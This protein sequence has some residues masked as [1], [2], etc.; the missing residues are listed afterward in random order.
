M[1]GAGVW[2]PPE[3]SGEVCGSGEVGETWFPPPLRAGEGYKEIIPQA[4]DY[5]NL[6]E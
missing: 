6:V 1:Q 5:S 4:F 2:D 3:G